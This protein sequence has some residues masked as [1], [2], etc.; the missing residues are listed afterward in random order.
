[1]PR[2]R[3]RGRAPREDLRRASGPGR[4]PTAHP[5]PGGASDAGAERVRRGLGRG[6]PGEPSGR[7]APRLR[8][9]SVHGLAPTDRVRGLPS[10]PGLY[11]PWAGTV[12]GPLLRDLGRDLP[13]PG[14]GLGRH[15]LAAGLAPGERELGRPA[16]PPA[17]AMVL[18]P[19]RGLRGRRDLPPGTQ[20]RGAVGDGE[21][22]VLGEKNIP[23]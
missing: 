18:V 5:R 1:M 10:P 9:R 15:A 22:G 8:R 20:G 13:G 17:D 12:A 23:R 19:A 11:R 21:L 4:G 14:R 2:A 3:R 7:G 16:R 6:V